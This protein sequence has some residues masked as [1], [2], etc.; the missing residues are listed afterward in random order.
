VSPAAASHAFLVRLMGVTGWQD[1]PLTEAAATVQIP[2]EDLRG[3]YAKWQPLAQ[4]IT[5]ALWPAASAA[6][7]EG[8]YDPAAPLPPDAPPGACPAQGGTTDVL[9]SGWAPP[10]AGQLTSGYGVRW[11]TMHRG[12]DIA[13]PLGTPIY[14]AYGGTVAAAGPASGFGNWVVLNHTTE[15]GGTISTVYGHMTA[16]S[17][18]VAV[19]DTVAAGQQIAAIGSEGESTGP[20]LHFEVWIDG[21]RLA[22]GRDID[23]APFLAARGIAW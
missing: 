23:P 21:A 4:Q 15:T 22:G 20:H 19:G 1:I 11:G 8:P 2:R 17:I 14:A 13:G 5:G 7:G 6:A 16:A 10:A 12:I 18:L 3:E 9:A